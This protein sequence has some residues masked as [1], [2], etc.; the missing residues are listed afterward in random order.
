MSEV[1]LRDITKTFDRHLAVDHIDLTIH[2][3]EFVTLLG[4]SGSGKTTCLRIIAG[5]TKPDSGRLRLGGEDAT[6]VPPY[7]RNMGIVFQN[8]ALFP[9]LTVAENVAYG[10]KARRLPKAEI[11]QRTMEALKLVHLEALADRYPKQTSGGQRQRVALAR[12]IAIRPSVLLLDEPLSAL[13]LKLRNG[14]QHE[15]RRIQRL[16]NITT[17]L[18]THDQGEAFGMSDRIAVM[19]SG[20]IVQ[21]D[22]PTGLYRQPTSQYVATFVGTSNFLDVTVERQ[23]G[24]GRHLVS[25]AAAPNVVFETAASALTL[26]AGERAVLSIRPEHARIKSDN[27]DGLQA[28]IQ[29]ITY[30]GESW[31]LECRHAGG[32]FILSVPGSGAPPGVGTAVTLDLPSEHS[33]LLK[34][35]EDAKA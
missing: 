11:N 10:L 8:Y 9:H 1:Q 5:F 18:V 12:A 15:I 34:V 28:S 20:K 27:V 3:G 32:S 25:L 13:D 23:L 19:R 7:K 30:T 14:L 33:A 26:S 35:E 6:N 16:L 29:K 17:L 4:A 22:T 24:G 31:I 2:E 21:I